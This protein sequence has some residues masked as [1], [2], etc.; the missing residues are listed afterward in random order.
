MTLALSIVSHGHGEQ[1]QH[2]LTLLSH[3]QDAVLGRI[4]LTLNMSEPG[5]E[6]AL[7]Q[8][9]A[10]WQG[11]LD[12][13]LIH[14]KRPLGFGENHNQAFG[15]EQGEST[16]A[17]FFVVMNPDISWREAPWPAMLQ[18]AA[19]AGVGCVFPRQVDVHGRTQDHAR[20]VPTPKVLLCRYLSSAHARHSGS[21]KPDW[22]NAALLLFRS[23]VFRKLRG[24]DTSYHMYCED[25]DICLRMQLMGYSLA[26][27][28]AA[29]VVHDANRASHR[30]LRHL[31]WHMRS[32]FRLWRSSAYQQYLQ[33]HEHS[34]R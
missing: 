30:D 24:F 14:N 16:P 10:P 15:C 27:A 17:S 2:L 21:S 32:L 1:V 28:G 25:V 34:H 33:K 11:R 13:R 9:D 7:A 31:S 12:V 3:S 26:E 29:C 4:W 19:Q 23:E 22:A 18:V 8:A 6:Q 5:L 20:R